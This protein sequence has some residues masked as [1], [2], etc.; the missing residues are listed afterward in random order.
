VSELTRGA[1][2]ATASE[3]IAQGSYVVTEIGFEKAHIQDFLF[4]E[5]GNRGVHPKEIGFR[6]K[7]FL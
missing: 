4:T 5:A 2:Q 1:I 7:N 6:P 3:G